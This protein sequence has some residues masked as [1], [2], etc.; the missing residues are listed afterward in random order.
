MAS[1]LRGDTAVALLIGASGQGCLRESGPLG[2]TPKGA[3]L[4]HLT[5]RAGFVL[6]FGELDF[7]G[8]NLGSLALGPPNADFACWTWRSQ[9]AGLNFAS[10]LS[11][12]IRSYNLQLTRTPPLS[13]LSVSVASWRWREPNNDLVLREKVDWLDTRDLDHTG[14]VRDVDACVPHGAAGRNGSCAWD[15]AGLLRDVGACILLST[16]GCDTLC[17]RCV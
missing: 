4:S 17:S 16:V 12:T 15:H 6:A 14:L 1:L 7:R 3:S 2:P 11:W 10:C 8:S 9:G 5:R 13:T